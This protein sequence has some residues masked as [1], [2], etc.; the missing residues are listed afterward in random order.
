MWSQTYGGPDKDY[1]NA[2]VQTSDGGYAL[3]GYTETSDAYDKAFCLVKT[4][5]NGNMEWNRTIRFSAFH[6]ANSLVET[7]D[8]GFALA[9][10]T[11]SFGAGG[12]DFW[13]VRTNPIVIPEPFPTT[14]IVAAI[15]IVAAVGT[16]VLVYF[17]KIKKTTGKAE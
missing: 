17:R 12:Y 2:M 6:R 10:N 8:G 16:A 7:S 14:W 3:V 9:G 11:K 15:V 1:V 13:L 5:A 4:D